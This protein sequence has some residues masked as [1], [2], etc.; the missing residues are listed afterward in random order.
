MSF[1]K[2]NSH[3]SSKKRVLKTACIALLTV[4]L[5]NACSY[6]QRQGADVEYD[7]TQSPYHVVGRGETLAG[8]AK[9]YGIDR[10]D[11]AQ[12]NGLKPPFKIM[13]GQ[14]LVVR[15]FSGK[16]PDPYE[17][18][19][20][21]GESSTRGG[22][23]VN[24]LA[25]LPGTEEENDKMTNNQ[26]FTAP[27]GHHDDNDHNY[28]E[29]SRNDMDGD[30]DGEGSGDEEQKEEA[31]KV[32]KSLP[33]APKSASFYSW[34]VKGKI[35]KGF[36]PGKNGHSG[37][38]VSAPKGTPVVAANNGVVARTEQIPGYGKLVLV[39][40][41]GGMVTIYAHLED[42]KVKRGD[43]VEAGQKIGTVGK[44]GNVKD[45][46]LHFEI[47]KNGKTPVDP[48]QFLD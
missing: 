48:T 27:H 1:S 3:I 32:V 18:P 35:V 41:D 11:L 34:P 36:Q 9:Q 15:S 47:R 16:S 29:T 19:A 31:P 12:L 46:Q 40:H 8:I 42:I 30:M 2:S 5:L 17:I 10:K 6:R 28:G 13:T 33:G 37:I 45:P 4:P 23:K 43:V 26:P 38:K 20:D 24:K 7:V 39:K 25:P 21:D 44:T 14:K 22:V